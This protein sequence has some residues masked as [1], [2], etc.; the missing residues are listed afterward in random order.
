MHSVL[1]KFIIIALGVELMSISIPF[2][3]ASVELSG[4]QHSETA[5]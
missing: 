1:T 5:K 4:M 2:L 3:L